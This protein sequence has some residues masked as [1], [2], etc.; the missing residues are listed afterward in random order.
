MTTPTVALSPLAVQHFVDN[1]GNALVGGK[2]FTYAAGTTTKLATYTD[3]TGGTPNTNPVILNSRGE[4]GVWLPPEQAYKFVLSPSTDTDPPTNPIWTVDGILSPFAEVAEVSVL[5]Y[6]TAGYVVGSGGNDTSAFQAAIAAAIATG[7]PYATVRV[8]KNT[9]GPYRISATLVL[10]K[11]VHIRGDGWLDDS[12]NPNS[13]ASPPGSS[14]LWIGGAGP[15]FQISSATPNNYL[16]G[17]SIQFLN[18][19]G[20]GAATYCVLASSISSWA[21]N[22]KLREVTTAGLR[23]DDANGVLS[24]YNYVDYL[25]FIY[26]TTTDEA[27]AHGL[28]LNGVSG[29]C[30]QNHIR[31]VEGL[32]KN[33]DMVH[34]AGADNN[35]FDHVH[36]ALDSGG[37][38]VTLAFLNG[39]GSTLSVN[40]AAFYVGGKVFYDTQ[41]RGN[42]I[43]SL[44][45]E[46][47]G[48]Y[49]E[50][51][52]MGSL[53][54]TV[55][56]YVLGYNYIT[57]E[58]KMYDAPVIPAP[59][60][61]PA[62]SGGATAVDAGGGQWP[63]ALAFANAADNAIGTFWA[64][65][66][67]WL[68]GHVLGIQIFFGMDAANTSAAT[69]WRIQ[70]THVINNDVYGG[71][72]ADQTF[73]VPVSD[74]QYGLNT[75]YLPFDTPMPVEAGM[76]LFI[77][78]DRLGA[79]GLD[80]ALGA[81]QFL[82][83]NPVFNGDGP[84]SAGAGTYA[85]N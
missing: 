12:A 55:S 53:I 35:V 73:T 60:W 46:G 40:N 9:S 61:S 31:H 48:V 13:Q 82:S 64:A 79:D 76:T 14:I 72:V 63:G 25:E 50:D 59:S 47:G 65:P 68:S 8:P 33:G 30:A 37:T 34:V 36:S 81:A 7:K 39:T 15:V 6:G 26:G 62:T 22:L 16:F 20:G 11:A 21:F 27:P 57:K 45:S 1:N 5:D 4:C 38:G 2:L 69:R 28:W 83:G 54:Y 23:I 74:A 67:Q 85:I 24:F 58:Y 75:A 19:S 44:D 70:M 3:S 43:V 42:R 66:P 10:A 80:T 29:G 17:G 52:T 49:A 78:I 32:N 51:P 71:A 18:I 77:R 56:D 84:I 41:T